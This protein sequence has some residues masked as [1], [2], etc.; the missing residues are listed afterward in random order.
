M[1]I[2][3]DLK[4][5][6]NQAS[7]TLEGGRSDVVPH[8][9]WVA[10]LIDIECFRLELVGVDMLT[11]SL[12]GLAFWHVC[13]GF[14]VILV[15]PCAFVS[16][17]LSER[18][19]LGVYESHVHFRDSVPW[20]AMLVIFTVGHE[21]RGPGVGLALVG[22]M[23]MKPRHEVKESVG[24]HVVDP[25]KYARIVGAAKCEDS[26]DIGTLQVAK[27]LWVEVKQQHIDPKVHHGGDALGVGEWW[28]VRT[29][30]WRSEGDQSEPDK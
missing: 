6:S 11:R 5:E 18:G 21:G 9:P 30:L 16:V 12:R 29:F 20:G 8:K 26:Q 10:V 28:S 17:S 1:D 7:V 22:I 13:R 27:S 14:V 15:D 23:S 19:R 24:A 4:A 2:D 3:W 25:P